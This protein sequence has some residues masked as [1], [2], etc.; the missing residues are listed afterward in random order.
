MAESV[1]K[2]EIDDSQIVAP[3][4]TV[5]KRVS[6]DQETAEKGHF[7][8]INL[9]QNTSAKIKNPLADLSPEEVLHDVEEFAHE[10]QLTDILPDLKKG[11]L[12]ARDPDNYESV[13]EMSAADLAAIDNEVT[14]KWRQ[15]VAL[16]FTIIL[17]SIGAAV[18]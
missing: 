12:I 1:G 6:D 7:E 15:P 5:Q 14:H 18:Q 16:Y 10:Y 11:A 13:P 3:N 2:A 4:V 8:H 17:C 9:N